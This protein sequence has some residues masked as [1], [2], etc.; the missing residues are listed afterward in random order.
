MDKM[1]NT[2]EGLRKRSIV[3]GRGNPLLARVEEL[4]LHFETNRGTVKAL[5]EV[6]FN[7]FEGETVALVG[8]TGC[9]KTVTARSFTRLV[10]T[11]PGRYVNGQ[12]LLKSGR[13]CA[14]CDGSGCGTCYDTGRAFD[15]VLEMDGDDVHDVRRKRI[16][17]VFQDP[18]EV[19]NPSMTIEAQV[20]ESVLIHHSREILKEAGVPGDETDPLTKRILE[21]YASPSIS[22]V[23][24]ALAS[25]PPLRKYRKRIDELVHERV[26]DILAETQIP[27]P[28]DIVT[29]YPHELSGGQQ[30]RVM[31]AM[32]L[33]AEPDLL[34]AD[35]P[36]T[37]L[38]VTIQ[39]RIL[40]LVED[41]Q[42]EFDTSVLYI[43]HDLSLV[44]DIADRV[45]VM[46]AGQVAE[47][48]DIDRVYDDPLHPYT[49][50]LLDAIP[51]A[52]KVGEELTGIEGSVPNMTNPPDGCRFCT[53]CPEVMEHCKDVD[54]PLVREGDDHTVA[55]H[56]YGSDPDGEPAKPT[57]AASDGG[58][59][60]E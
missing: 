36:T 40:N 54:P 12:L 44:E 14:D 42:E 26:V 49:W 15:D 41:L 48:G 24:S 33:V 37:A 45:V 23:E 20:A 58:G 6:S 3:D 30:Q 5:D 50:G 34:I 35:E 52:E 59:H 39:T 31:I 38:D 7:V 18:E 32:A 60:D 4:S 29:N 56:L 13:P 47:V 10:P 19:L 53:R 46:Y 28:E 55:C 9:G 21:E 57:A 27:S 16:A 22:R 2:T 1:M 8:E 11:P 17:M 51:T 25:V 43:T